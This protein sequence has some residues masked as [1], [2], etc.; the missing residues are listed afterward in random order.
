MTRTALALLALA[1]ISACELQ[2]RGDFLIGRMCDD[3]K[4]CDP[5]QV[6]LPHEIVGGQF[7]NFLCRDSAS[8]AVMQNRE[9]PLAYCGPDPLN[10]KVY[11]CPGDLVCNADRV[12]EDATTR[13]LVCTTK[14]SI[15]SPPYDGGM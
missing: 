9:P 6:C 2:E 13:P 15:F 3:D 12:R 7:S 5:G 11:K 10:N 8:F 1:V 14:N 4:G